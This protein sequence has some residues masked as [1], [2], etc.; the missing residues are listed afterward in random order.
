[1][2]T[3]KF[4][5]LSKKGTYADPSP[6]PMIVVTSLEA[7]LVLIDFLTGPWGR[8][9]LCQSAFRASARNSKKPKLVREIQTFFSF[10][11]G[12]FVCS[13]NPLPSLNDAIQ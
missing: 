1:M 4:W 7:R 10:D 13:R 12:S 5:L 11:A 2:G 8:E 6:T 3:P 9:L